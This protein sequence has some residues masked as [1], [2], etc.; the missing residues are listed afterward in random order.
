MP[1][2]KGKVAVQGAVVA[3][4][5]PSAENKPKHIAAHLPPAHEVTI[6]DDWTEI[7]CTKE[8]IEKGWVKSKHLEGRTV[9]GSKAI[10][11]DAG[12][13]G[14]VMV[15]KAAKQEEGKN[16][17]GYITDATEVK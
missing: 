8:K 13:H 9:V 1:D 12:G 11:R 4:K 16:S 2:A 15:R 17:A 3:K 14:S 10:I 5:E 6:D 7:Q